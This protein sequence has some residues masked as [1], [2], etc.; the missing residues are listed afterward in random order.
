MRKE[1]KDTKTRLDSSHVH[2]KRT[3][4]NSDQ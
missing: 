3:K 4:L 2:Q 1:E